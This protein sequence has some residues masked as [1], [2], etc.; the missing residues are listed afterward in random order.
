MHA[1]G[2]EAGVSG[3]PHGLIQKALQHQQARQFADAAD[4]YARLLAEWPDL[5]TSWYNFGYVLRQCRRF[6]EALA[7]YDEALKRGVAQPEEVRL[8]RAVIYADHLRRNDDALRE[9]NAALMLNPRYV[10]ALLNLANL[11]EDVGE[12]AEARRIYED[13]LA[14]DPGCHLALAR[15]AGLTS[16]AG[17][18]DPVVARLKRTII[19]PSVAP[20][21]KADLGFALGRLLDACG[22]YDEAFAAYE[23]ANRA[24]RRSAGTRGPL[25]DRRKHEALIARIIAAFP[26]APALQ[27]PGPRPPV[28]ICGMFRSGSTLAEQILAAHPAVTAGGEIDILPELVRSQLSSFPPAAL[29][30]KQA[31]DLARLYR[32]KLDRLFPG[33]RCVIDKRPDNFLYVG[34]IKRMFPDARIVHTVRHPLDNCLSVF[35]LHL[36]HAMAYA[37]DLADIAHYYRQYR[38]LMDHWKTLYPGD[39]L[40][41]DYDALVRDPKPA[42]ETLLSFAGLDWDDACLDFHSARSSVKTASVWQVREPVYRRS[43]GRW[44]N[45]EKHLGP[46]V[47]GLRA[48]L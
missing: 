43:S 3:S 37:L 36:D 23:D 44:R 39:I 2:E 31:S 34:L 35:F 33:A 29:T 46:L 4:C 24:S 9:L 20:A 28:F 5:P 22:A 6:D 14:L 15:L 18:E 8:N 21:D 30:E 1:E 12:A 17:P 32:D 10:P 48:F 16:P 40:D 42:I 27:S 41:F 38:R 7:A 13:I 25:Y 26:D 19:S 11:R 45:Y 47:T